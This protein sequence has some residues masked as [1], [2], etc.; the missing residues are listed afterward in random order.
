VLRRLN[1]VLGVGRI[2]RHGEPDDFKWVVEGIPAIEN[3]LGVVGP[4]LG[5]VKR[6]QARDV[7]RAFTAQVRLSGSRTH[8]KRGHPYDRRAVTKAGKTRAYCNTCAR[9]GARRIRA[10]QGIN[11]R[12][13]KDEGRRY[14][15]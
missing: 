13:F 5:E 11:P 14:T 15:E 7:M 1:R 3:V 8:C 9:L 6:D 2:E 4:W 12:Q 10:A